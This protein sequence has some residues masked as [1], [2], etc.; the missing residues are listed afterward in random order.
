MGHSHLRIDTILIERIAR[1]VENCMAFFFHQVVTIKLA[2]FESLY[3]MSLPFFLCHPVGSLAQ[4]LL[5][6]SIPIT[7]PKSKAS[8]WWT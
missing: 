2:Q 5:G 6:P 7:I 1:G 4:N 8:I 3:P